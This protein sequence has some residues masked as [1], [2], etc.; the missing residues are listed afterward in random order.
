MTRIEIVW[1]ATAI[2]SWVV[3][4]FTGTGAVVFANRR[5]ARRRSS[6][7]KETVR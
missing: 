3:G 4:F 6:S 5:A 2:G 7:A 1:W